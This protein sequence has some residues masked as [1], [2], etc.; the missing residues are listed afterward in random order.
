[1]IVTTA[2]KLV[3]D[4]KN[5]ASRSTFYSNSYPYNLCYVY[6]TGEVSADCVNLYKALLN[7]Y[8]VNN[9]TAGYF[10]RSLSNTGDVT[11]WGLMK[12]CTDVTSDFSRIITEPNAP[13]LL[14]KEGH[15]GGFIGEEVKINGN[16]YNCIEATAWTGDWG[17]TGIIYTWVDSDGTRR[18]HKGGYSNG[19]WEYNGLMTPWVDYKEEPKPEP[20]PEPEKQYFTDVTPD[21]SSYR[22][23]QWMAKEGYIVGYKDG[24]F[25]P[26][27][28][29]TREQLCVILWRMAGRPE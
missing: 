17:H 7:G 23:I 5:L 18:R 14:Y 26:K 16:L 9:K 21:M 6:A 22:A 2:K 8:D 28:N 15:I 1:M 29:M 19:K 3:S 13:R 27:N 24:T 25:R 11:E 10:Q 20:E 12:Q 4:L